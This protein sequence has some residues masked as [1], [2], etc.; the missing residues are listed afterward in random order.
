VRTESVVD[1][2]ELEGHRYNIFVGALQA[3][4]NS[5]EILDRFK[6]H[7]FYGKDLDLG[8]IEKYVGAVNDQVIAMRNDL[9]TLQGSSPGETVSLDLDPRV[10]HALLGS[11]TEHGEIATAMLQAL[12]TG[13]LDVV[14]VCEELGDSDWYKALFYEA[15]GIDWESVQAMII[16]KLEIRFA[17]NIFTEEEAKERDL[18]A[19]RKI[20]VDAIIESVNEYKATSS[21]S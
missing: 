1:K 21:G 2:I 16:K 10:F 6:K 5:A 14:N 17:G 4:E 13:E 18:E 15:T 19:E 9:Y 8:D 12:A 3:F 11:I 7:A 20:L